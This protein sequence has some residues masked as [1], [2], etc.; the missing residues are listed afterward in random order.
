MLFAG[1]GIGRVVNPDEAY[2]A[3]RLEQS[4]A[5]GANRFGVFG[6]FE[7]GRTQLLLGSP[8]RFERMRQRFVQRSWG[9]QE[10]PKSNDR[11]GPDQ[12]DDNK[13]TAHFVIL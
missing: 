9:L 12:A 5:R 2:N 13:G 11:A 3:K 7:K 8:Q 6:N 1:V 10:K 4:A